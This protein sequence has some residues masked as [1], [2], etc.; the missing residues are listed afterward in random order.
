MHV[1]LAGATGYIASAILPRLLER[2]HD[3]TSVVRGDDRAEAVRVTGATPVVDDLADPAGLVSL[4]RGCD[5][6][7]HTASTG[8]GTSADVD[9]AVADAVIEA[10]AGT[11]K[12]Y[13]HTGG[14]WVYGAGTWIE[15]TDPYSPPPIRR[16]PILS[17]VAGG[18][19]SCRGGGQ[20]P[21]TPFVN[22][23]RRL[24]SPSMRRCTISA[25]GICIGAGGGA[26]RMIA[27]QPRSA[28]M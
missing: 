15:E 2:G 9:R 17:R 25:G 8:D 5:G 20:P 28:Q 7:I 18:P 4:L 16:V 10:L 22:A 13:V 12:P 21:S 19:R 3:V 23:S 1:L 6:A 11:G 27:E 24:R 14:C 26:I